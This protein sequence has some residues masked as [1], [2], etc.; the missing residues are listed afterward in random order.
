MEEAP[1]GGSP[2]A[3][4]PP[5]PPRA[6]SRR[7]GHRSSP[8]PA[9]EEDA[10][11]EEAAADGPCPD[12]VIQPTLVSIPGCLPPPH[13]DLAS[14]AALRPT[15]LAD[16][17]LPSQR[18]TR[19]SS[20]ALSPSPSASPASVDMGGRGE[21]ATVT[22]RRGR[23]PSGAPRPSHPRQPAA[24]PRRSPRLATSPSSPPSSCVEEMALDGPGPVPGTSF[25]APQHEPQ[26]RQCLLPPPL[27]TLQPP[28][29]QQQ[30]SATSPGG[31]MVGITVGDPCQAPA[32]SEAAAHALRAA[33]ERQRPVAPS[34]AQVVGR[35]QGGMWDVR[36]PPGTRLEAVERRARRGHGH[37]MSGLSRYRRP[38]GQ[39][40]PRDRRRIELESRSRAILGSLPGVQGRSGGAAR[41]PRLRTLPHGARAAEMDEL[42]AE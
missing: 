38:E 16:P 40:P 35:A 19:A 37:D 4:P 41:A 31:V 12:G 7:G 25:L 22:P 14:L 39:L 29:R 1:V 5:R 23:P 10:V 34:G 15:P 27:T 2:P 24:S 32:P 8:P 36:H 18:R 21:P 17:P 20:P 6:H 13:P 26:R 9:P 42:T 33:V 30:Q 28:H 3:A 11:M